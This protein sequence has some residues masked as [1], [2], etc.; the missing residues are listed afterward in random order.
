GLDVLSP[1]LA[2][3]VHRFHMN[4]LLE[5][6]QDAGRGVRAKGGRAGRLRQDYDIMGWSRDG[7]IGDILDQYERHMHFLHVVR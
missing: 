4:P 7:V 6:A 3:R 5:K 1:G 2:P